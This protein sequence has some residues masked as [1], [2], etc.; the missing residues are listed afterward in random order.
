MTRVVLTVGCVGKTYADENFSNVYDFD[1][2]TLDYKYDKTGYEHLS[3]EEFKG[4]PNRKI[5]DGWFEKYMTDFCSVIDSGDYDVVTGWLQED[6]I[7]YLVDKGYDV[8]LVLVSPDSDLEVYKERAIRRGNSERY[9]NNLRDYYETTYYQHVLKQQVKRAWILSSP[10]VLSDLLVL[11][12][13]NLK[14]KSWNDSHDEYHTY[15]DVVRN[16]VNN[17]FESRLDAKF[18]NAYTSLVLNMLE[19]NLR[20]IDD[21]VITNRMVHDSWSSVMFNED[22]SHPSLIPY[23]CLSKKTR[24]LDSHY[25]KILN[26]VL[27]DLSYDLLVGL[28]YTDRNPYALSINSFY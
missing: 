28:Q 27:S 17:A 13:T 16:R 25:T 3:D 23:T 20:G 12:G 15:F 18:V 1:K 7:S 26:R 10:I 14:W 4:I 9:W 2:H 11:T 21:V 22:T 8:E 5:K 6:T 19:L 24:D